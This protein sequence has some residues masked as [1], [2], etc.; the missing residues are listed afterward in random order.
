MY[1]TAALLVG[2]DTSI[3]AA[4]EASAK[5]VREVMYVPLSCTCSHAFTRAGAR[6]I[7]LI[8]QC[9]YKHNPSLDIRILLPISGYSTNS[10]PP[11]SA[12]V[13]ALLSTCPD[14]QSVSVLPSYAYLKSRVTELSNTPFVHINTDPSLAHPTSDN[15]MADETDGKGTY[16][17]VALG[18]TFDRIHGGHNLLLAYSAYLCSNRIIVGV[19]DGPLLNNKVLAELIEPV[20]HRI[21]NVKTFLTDIKPTLL[22]DVVAIDDV[23]GPTAYDPDIDCIVVSQETSKGGE[24]VNAERQKKVKFLSSYCKCRYDAKNEALKF[25]KCFVTKK[26][27]FIAICAR[28]RRTFFRLAFVKVI[29]K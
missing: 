25:Y 3:L 16:N 29:H 15:T 12:T 5:L 26:I 9:G 27:N 23:F 2:T 8:H 10:Y 13:D 1:R 28:W 22:M 19:S 18:G 7:E 11:L 21:S 17:T 20:E 4:L 24:I 14:L 6:R